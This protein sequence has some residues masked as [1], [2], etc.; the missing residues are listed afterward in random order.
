MLLLI[1]KRLFRFLFFSLILQ[2]FSN[3]VI[4]QPGYWQQHVKYTMD[5]DMNVVTNRFTGKQQL[6]YT[7]NS[8]DTLKKVFYHLYWNA[9]QPNSMM[10]S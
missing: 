6:E 7:N 1:H 10:D 8:P 9:F 4:A 2:A 3:G 5:I